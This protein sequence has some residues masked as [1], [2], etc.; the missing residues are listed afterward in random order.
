MRFAV[1][2]GDGKTI[3]VPLPAVEIGI[4]HELPLPG[5]RTAQ[6]KALDEA[7]DGHSLRLELEGM[8][9]SEAVLYLRRNDSA[10]Q[11]RADGGE[12]AGDALHVKFGAGSGYVA[13]TVMLRW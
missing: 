10:A 5:A 2:A 6:M 8:S 4:G 7:V 13:Q 9:G 3:R 11:V 1:A 12:I